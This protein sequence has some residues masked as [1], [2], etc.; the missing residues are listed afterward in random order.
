MQ[1]PVVGALRDQLAGP[2]VS[3]SDGRPRVTWTPVDHH[4]L[5]TLT[6]LA[7]AAAT[8]LLALWG[9]PPIDLHGPLHRLGIM[10]PLCGGTRAAYYTINGQWARA[11]EYNPLGIAAVSAALLGTLRVGVG[12][13]TRRWLTVTFHWTPRRARF[14]IVA[15]V[16][17][18]GV[19]E[20]R[21][22]LEAPL[23]LAGTSTWR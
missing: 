10:D 22:Q 7:G 16:V 12:L 8:A 11:W 6:A 23:L 9:L 17:L 20:V 15:T 3:A 1:P 5:L 21:Q 14:A 13:L 19:L 18:L 2:A 4:R